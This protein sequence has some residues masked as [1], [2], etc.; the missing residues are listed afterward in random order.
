MW[1]HNLRTHSEGNI[2]VSCL[3]L[4]GHNPST[5]SETITRIPCLVMHSHKPCT[6]LEA[7]RAITLARTL[8]SSPSPIILYT[9]SLTRAAR[10]QPLHTPRGVRR[11]QSSHSEVI[12]LSHNPLRTCF[13]TI[14]FAR[15]LRTSPLM[16]HHTHTCSLT[17]Y[18]YIYL[19][20]HS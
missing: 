6:H 15:T 5:H 12:A 3:V 9:H 19:C 1:G 7:C 11:S 13:E 17:P 4:Q 20:I 16:H 10:P 8:K 2:L 14:T 18:S